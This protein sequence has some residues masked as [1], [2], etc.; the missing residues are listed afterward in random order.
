MVEKNLSKDL[1]R[2]KIDKHCNEPIRLFTD[3]YTIYFGLE[4]HSKV[5]E[6]HII[7]HSEK[8]Y[9][10]GEN[11]V[12]NCEN[13]HSLLRQYLRIFRGVSKKK[14][15]TYVKFFQFTF[16]KGVNWFGNAI[17]LILNNCTNTGR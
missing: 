11:H 17:Q 2:E 10:D 15:N 6:H 9:A 5:K 16:N 12:N 4:G 8:E 13:R 7:K 1:I 3:N 14:L